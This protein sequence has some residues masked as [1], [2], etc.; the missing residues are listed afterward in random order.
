MYTYFYIGAALVWLVG[1]RFVYDDWKAE[2]DDGLLL[3]GTFV[4]SI[5]A[6]LWPIFLITGT[7]VG[8]L[9]LIIRSAFLTI[10]YLEKRWAR[11]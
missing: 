3:I 9:L 4:V 8:S 7:L 10:R 2:G 5:A 1:M 11:G 6:A